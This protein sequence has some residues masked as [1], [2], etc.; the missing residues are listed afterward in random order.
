ME[1]STIKNHSKSRGANA[2]NNGKIFEQNSDISK[3]LY[4]SGYVFEK[5]G[6]GKYNNYLYKQMDDCTITYLSQSGFKTYFNKKYNIITCRHPDEAY[7]IMTPHKNVVKIL[8]KKEQNCEGSAE[9]KLWAGPSLKREYE[10]ILGEN[11]KIEYA[12]CINTFLSKK[13]NSD[14][15]KYKML[16]KI[17]EENNISIFCSSEQ[18]YYGDILKWINNF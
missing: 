4:N 16:K 9:T 12:Y 10:L 14:I 6:K 13:I 11:Y 3:Y 18:N 7:I 1:N 17:L 8:E 5:M 15:L 2:S